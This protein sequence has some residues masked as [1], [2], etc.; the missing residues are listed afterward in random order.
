MCRLGSQFNFMQCMHLWY[1]VAYGYFI[2]TIVSI[3][4]SMISVDVQNANPQRKESRYELCAATEI[5]LDVRIT[6]SLMFKS[7]RKCLPCVYCMY[8]LL[9]FDR[10]WNF[11]VFKVT[12]FFFFSSSKQMVI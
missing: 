8:C 10:G 1:A 9:Y 6:L 7:V 4:F 5:G 12:R 3:F 11:V 2:G